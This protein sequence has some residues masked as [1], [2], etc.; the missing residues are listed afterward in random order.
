MDNVFG[1]SAA[2]TCDSRDIILVNTLRNI[3][4][5]FNTYAKDS[6][7]YDIKANPCK[8]IKSYINLGRLYEEN[9]FPL[10]NTLPLRINLRPRYITIDTYILIKVF[11]KDSKK[12]KNIS[13]NKEPVWSQIFKTD[14]KP[15]KRNDKKFGFEYMIKTDG[16]GT[17]LIFMKSKEENKKIRKS[18]KSKKKDKDSGDNE[19]DEEES[20]EEE[21]KY[22][23]D[24]IEHN[25]ELLSSK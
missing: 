14:H 10:F 25:V 15:F 16:I 21:E 19:E 6:K 22:K 8:Y 23:M 3:L 4:F 12:L 1:L 9:N 13:D 5:P 2:Y 20:E 11:I 17:S 24:Y 18:T 7:F